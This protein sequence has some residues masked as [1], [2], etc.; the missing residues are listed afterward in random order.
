MGLDI[1]LP[2]GMIFTA[3]GLILLGYGAATNHNAMYAV[4]MGLN[5]NV[6]WGAVMLVF[7]GVMLLLARRRR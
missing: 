1:R 6:L 5:I 4:S 3:L 7:G 2:L